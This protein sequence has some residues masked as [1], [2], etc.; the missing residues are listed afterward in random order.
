MAVA[1]NL[2]P[3][4]AK[5]FARFLYARVPGAARFRFAF[6][7][8][9]AQYVSKPEFGGI[10]RLALGGGQIIDVGASRGQSIAAFRRLA[11]GCKVVAFEP[12]PRSAACLRRYFRGAEE[13]VLHDC[14]LGCEAGQFTFFI[15]HYGMW[16]CDGM[17]ATSL[18]EA[19]LWLRDGGRM[20]RFNERLL[21]VKSYQVEYR[22]LDSFALSPILIKLHAQ[23]AEIDILKG[24]VDTLC[25]SQ[26]AIMC[27]FPT[28]AVTIFLRAM[29]YQP[30]RYQ[31][32]AFAPGFAKGRETFTWF[33]KIGHLERIAP[34]V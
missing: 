12:E 17:A 19:T 15:P 7:D 16:D 30:F 11:P 28:P 2:K 5:A 18:E 20:F 8:I 22:T 13:I 21:S 34:Q 25:R 24:A 32:G 27:A 3:A 4:N 10:V 1:L 26:P 33:L 23:G 9:A 31:A 29:R 6:K 14:A